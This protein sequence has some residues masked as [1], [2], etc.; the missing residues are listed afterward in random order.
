MAMVIQF[1][2]SFSVACSDL[3]CLIKVPSADGVSQWMSGHKTK[4]N[5]ITKTKDKKDEKESEG[6]GLGVVYGDMGL[7]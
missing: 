2:L 4:S 3:A 6:G 5:H 7:V 1:F